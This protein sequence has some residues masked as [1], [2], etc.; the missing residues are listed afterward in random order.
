M[1][2]RLEVNIIS[3]SL[4]SLIFNTFKS[5]FFPINQGRLTGIKS[6]LLFLIMPSLAQPCSS[7][8]KSMQ[9]V[10]GSFRFD[11]DKK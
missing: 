6:S 5:L 11:F 1:W 9:D 3:D 4:I 8:R 7:I 2:L 10:L